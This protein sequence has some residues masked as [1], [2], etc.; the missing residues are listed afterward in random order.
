MPIGERL[1]A[2]PRYIKH[3]PVA[4]WYG[5]DGS[6]IDSGTAHIVHSNLSHLSAVN[7]RSLGTIPGPGLVT[8]YKGTENTYNTLN[9]L[10]ASAPTAGDENQVLLSTAWVDQYD[11]LC[12]GSLS[13]VPVTLGVD[14]PGYRPRP[15][16]VIV[17]GHKGV[18]VGST[19]YVIAALTSSSAPPSLQLPLVSSTS[20][21]YA[22]GSGAFEFDTTLTVSGPVRAQRDLVSR[23]SA[24]GGD[25]HTLCLDLYLWVGWFSLGTGS[26]VDSI[27]SIS[28]F[29]TV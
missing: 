18:D 23:P 11:C 4:S 6:S 24:A 26:A 16:R 12:M 25:S 15:V 5:L 10:D 7:L 9:L 21:T 29:E 20:S 19:M 22:S 17:N 2:T 13:A 3:P 28:A 8:Q 1:L 14:P 27:Y